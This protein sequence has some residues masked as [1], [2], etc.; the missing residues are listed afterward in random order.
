M[1][2]N[3]K[4]IS[5]GLSESEVLAQV[6][7]EVAECLADD[8]EL[9]AAVHGALSDKLTAAVSKGLAAG[10]AA[11]C[12]VPAMD[13]RIAVRKTL[14]AHREAV[15]SHRALTVRRN[16]IRQDFI[17]TGGNPADFPEFWSKTRRELVEHRTLTEIERRGM[18]ARTW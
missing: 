9:A 4:E 8:A 5:G 16:I 6:R 13:I 3:F 12:A 10:H 1:D 7:A 15:E 11:G 2:M 14:D 18:C 17:R